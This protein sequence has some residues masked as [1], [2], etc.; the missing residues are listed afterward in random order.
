M[1]YLP[2]LIRILDRFREKHI[3]TIDSGFRERKENKEF[4]L[5]DGIKTGV[6]H[7]DS[8]AADTLY[9]V[10]PSAPKYSTLKNRLKIRLLNSLFHLNWKRAGF[11]ESAQAYYTC[12]K[13]SFMVHVLVALGARRVA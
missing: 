1:K 11:S 3:E 13:H 4:Q 7:N 10:Q 9:Q 6:F 2:E 5:Y 8:E 12:R